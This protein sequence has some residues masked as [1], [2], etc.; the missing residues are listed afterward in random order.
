MM[1][2]INMWHISQLVEA[3]GAMS[4]EQQ[5]N[6][7]W[8][9]GLRPVQRDFRGVFLHPKLALSGQ[10]CNSNV[11]FLR[12]V[13]VGHDLE[14]H[15]T[16]AMRNPRI[17]STLN[18]HV[19]PH[20]QVSLLSVLITAWQWLEIF[21]QN[22]HVDPKGCWTVSQHFQAMCRFAS[23]KFQVFFKALFLRSSKTSWSTSRLKSQWKVIW[24]DVVASTRCIHTFSAVPKLTNNLCWNSAGK[25]V[26]DFFW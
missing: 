4:M 21:A 12:W 24:I 20:L 11:Y 8:T 15:G 9:H 13:S 3:T 17:F 22:F 16:L 2:S 6:F 7:S 5:K 23:S 25:T 10:A 26:N 19:W 18:V 1:F 14:T